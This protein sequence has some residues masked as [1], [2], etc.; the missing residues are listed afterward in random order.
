MKLNTLYVTDL[1]GTLLGR[2][3]LI[4]SRS[5]E[6]ISSLSAR[7]AMITCATARTPATV[8]P[9]F[10]GTVTNPPAVVMTGTAYWLREEACFRDP[11][12]LP[13][14][15]LRLALEIFKSHGVHPYVYVM[16]EDGRRLDV[17][18]AP[19]NL[20]AAEA[21]F[22]HDRTGLEL[23]KFHLGQPAPGRAAKHTMLLYAMGHSHALVEAFEEFRTK[24]DC[25]VFCYPDIFNPE[26]YN[27]EVFPP[28]VTK[29][30]AVL[31]L[32]EELGA[33]RLVVFGDNLNDLPMLEVAD[34]AVAVGNALDEVKAA[35]DIVIE[36]N[37]TDSV[38]R[39]I[40]SDFNN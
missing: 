19:D 7:G 10:E 15:E 28:K 21:A 32:K 36:P 12:F 2:D 26:V 11:H 29:A 25:S 35:A 17:Y 5:S 14:H 40:E 1:D 27:L 4:S 6:I 38:A 22:Y 9:L 8:V 31:K 3:S 18:H 39:F 37:Y 30:A 13:E 20:N 33:E 23:K 34:V 16:A 24:T